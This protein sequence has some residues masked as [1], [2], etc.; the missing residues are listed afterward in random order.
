MSSSLLKYDDILNYKKGEKTEKLK[1]KQSKEANNSSSEES[2]SESID[3][4]NLLNFETKKEIEIYEKLKKK[5]NAE[6]TEDDLPKIAAVLK[7]NILKGEYLEDEIVKQETQ[8]NK[9]KDERLQEQN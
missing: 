1:K 2:S 4:A 6:V 5:T 7:V 9:L 3:S 8:L